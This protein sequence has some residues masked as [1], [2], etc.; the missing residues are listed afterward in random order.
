MYAKKCTHES[1]VCQMIKFLMIY[2]LIFFLIFLG[3]LLR[4]DKRLHL[5]KGHRTKVR[6]FRIGWKL[7]T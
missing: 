2:F 7:R 4:G 5:A 6:F 3:T 1:C